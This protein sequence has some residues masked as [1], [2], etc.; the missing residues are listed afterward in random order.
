MSR[1]KRILTEEEKEQIAE[2]KKE[3]REYRDNIAYIKQK[4]N[5]NTEL[6]S[7][8][9]SIKSSGQLTGL[10][11]PKG[12]NPDSAP[13]EANLDK[14]NELE[15]ECIEKLKETLVAK[16]VIENKIKRMEQPYRSIL[17]LKYISGFKLYKI[18]EELNYSYRHIK[19]LHRDALLV[20]ANL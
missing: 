4:Q 9:E 11:A 17:Y 19:N 2:A 13:L 15:T 5:D 6:R 10:P 16:F 14:I 12:N 3:L 7:I 20:Y 1:Q 18:S 8:I